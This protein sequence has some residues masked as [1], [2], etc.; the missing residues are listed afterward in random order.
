[1]KIDKSYMDDKNPNELMN[2]YL[3]ILVLIGMNLDWSQI[4]IVSPA[5]IYVEELHLWRNNCSIIS[6]EFD[7]PKDSWPHLK[8]I[9]L[10]E[11]NIC[12]WEEIQGFR[13][14]E[15]LKKLG[16]GINQIKEINFRPG[17]SELTTLDIYQNL[18]DNYISIDQLSEYYSLNRIRIAD[19]PIT[20]GDKKDS[21]RQQ[22]L[23]RIRYLKFYGGSK[24][25]EREK[26]DCE[27][28]YM[29]QSYLEFQKDHGKVDH[30]EDP[31]LTEYMTKYHARFYE[32]VEKFNFNMQSLNE[33]KDS[34]EINIKSKLVQV[35]LISNIEATMGKTLKKK[36]LPTMTVESLKG[37][38][39]KLFKADILTMELK[40]RDDDKSD[41][42]YNIDENL[43]QL[44][45]Y[46]IAD[47]CEIVIQ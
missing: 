25:D 11:N 32:L 40:F 23:A 34:N 36:L 4:E 18:L 39:C 21:A 38:W 20:S 5:L 29:K 31:K 1:M 27:M 9:N 15:K 26:Q 12:D 19:N 17:F 41:V 8:Y 6:S 2:P 42:Y 45:F 37:I 47:G 33:H 7:I 14:L 3:K 46:G 44:S 10:E 24:V 28:Y 13:K 22:I 35:K 30:L 43:R 16:L